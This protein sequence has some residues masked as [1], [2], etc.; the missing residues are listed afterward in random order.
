MSGLDTQIDFS[1]V[2]ASSVHDMKNSVGMLL[3]SVENI[4]E[5]YK[6]KI[7]TENSDFRTLHYEASRIN[8]ELIQLLS[9]YR[10]DNGFMPVNIDEYFVMDVFEDQ[11]A[12]NQMLLDASGIEVEFDLPENLVWYFDTDLIGG[13]LHNILVNCIRYTKSK[14]RLSAEK[15]DKTLIIS[16][17]DD[18]PGYPKDMLD[19]PVNRVECAEVSKGN[20]HLGLF[21]AQ[22]IASLHK[23]GERRGSIHLSNGGDLGGGVFTLSLP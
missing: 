20:T 18:G 22:N 1:T 21:F 9:L 17:S 4:M 14:I 11:V 23:E 19:N 2:L 12:R 5:E 15:I 8:G 3:S 6:D 13:V 7:E 16:I 10:M